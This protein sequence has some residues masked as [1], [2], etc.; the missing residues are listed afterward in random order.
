[1]FRSICYSSGKRWK[2]T[3][4]NF[5]DYFFKFNPSLLHQRTNQLEKNSLPL[6]SWI[7]F[8]QFNWHGLICFFF[9]FSSGITGLSQ[10]SKN[11]FAC[12]GRKQLADVHN[13]VIAWLISQSCQLWEQVEERKRDEPKIICSFGGQ[14]EWS[15]IYLVVFCGFFILYISLFMCICK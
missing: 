5:K 12:K 10:E 14:M 1:M 13:P 2:H 4:F 7:Y 11:C 15:P 8:V 6:C 9:S 3:P